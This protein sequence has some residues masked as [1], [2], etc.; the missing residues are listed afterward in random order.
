MEQTPV[1]N[2]VGYET[3]EQIAA[4]LH[5][6]VPTVYTW[7]RRSANPLPARR[8]THKVLLFTWPEVRAW[9]EAG[10][11]LRPKSQKAA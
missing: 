3:A 7:A 1:V 11:T 6:A 10:G 2:D 4:R 8:L 5:V 9:V